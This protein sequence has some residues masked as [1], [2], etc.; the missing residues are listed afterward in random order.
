[1][2]DRSSSQLLVASLKRD[3]QSHINEGANYVWE[4]YR[5]EPFVHKFSEAIYTFQERVDELISVENSIDLEL[6]S[7]DTCLYKQQSFQDI[8]GKI[9]KS[10]DD[11]SLRLYS[12]LAQ[13]VQQLDEQIEKKLAIRLQ[14]AIIMWTNAL[15]Q[16]NN[17]ENNFDEQQKRRRS[18]FADEDDVLV[19][20]KTNN[21]QTPTIR[22]LLHQLRTSNQLLYVAPPMNDAREQLILELYEYEGIITNQKRIQHSRYQLGIESESEYKTTF[23]SLLNKLPLT[24]K[25]LEDA[26]ETIGSLITAADDYVNTWLDFQSL[27]DLQTDQ[28]YARLG[29][30]ITNWMSCLNEMKDARKTFDTQ[31]TLK[32]FGPITIDYNK[33]QTKVTMKYDSWHKEIL[34]KFGTMLSQ[35]MHEFHAH[36]SKA[37]TDLESQSLEAS[38]TAEAVGV[39]TYVQALKRKMKNWEKQV[40]EYKD[41]QKILERQRYQF[42][43]NWLYVDN[44]EG[45]WGAFNEILSRKNSS[46]QNQVVQLRN[47]ITAEDKIVETRTNDLL[48]EWEKDKP[49]AGHLSPEDALAQLSTYDIKLMK[50]KDERDNIIKAK[51][52][53]EITESTS[54][55][56]QSAQNRVRVQVALEELLDLKG[57][58]NELMLIWKQINELKEKQW[59]TIQPRKLRQSLEELVQQL[60]NLPQRL[61]QYDS[62]QHVKNVLQQ[63][64]KVNIL[65][66]EL[67]SE[68][69]KE[70][71]WKQLMRR[72]SIIWNLNDMTLGQVWSIDLQRHESIIREILTIAQGE[73][74]L[75]EF[76]KQVSEIWKTYQLELINYQQKCKVIK[77]WDDLFNKIKEH[78]NSI[79]A[80]KLS[81]Y[82]K[83]FEEEANVW[84]DR[85]N[86]INALFDVW[87]DVQRRW[88]YLDG[89]FGSSA[90]IKHLLPVETSRFQSVSTEFLSLMKRV[91]KSPLVIDVLNIQG[92]QK[93]LERLAE[94]LAKIQKALGEY[95]ERERASFP[96]FYFVGDEDL[97][98][99]IGNSK[100]IGR[101]QKHFKK[102]FAGVHTLLMNEDN[103]IVNGVVSKEGEEV[104]F[105]NHISIMDS[106][107]NEWLTKV[108]KEISLTL[109]KLLS[110][111]IPE[112]IKIQENLADTNAFIQWLDQYQAQLVVLAFQ[113]SWSESIERIL[114]QKSKTNNNDILPNALQGI[115]S[116]LGILANM[117]LGDQPTVRRR[118][119]EHLIIEHVHKRDCTRALIEKKIGDAR[120]F[121]WLSQMRLYFDPTI[122]NVLEQLK[123]RMANA[124]FHYGF[125]YLGIQDRLVQTPLTDR[126]FLTMTQALNAKFGGSPFGPAGT[127]KTESV[128]AL[129]HALGRFVLV[130]NCD[131]SFDFQ[132]MG[133]LFTGLC[134]V[135]AWGCFDEFNRLEERMLSAVSQQIQTIQE[136]LREL[137]H[138]DNKSVLKIELVG[139]SV[140]VN[141]NMAIFIT[142]NPGYAG[143]SNLPDNLKMLFRSLAMTVPDKVLI[144]QV[145]LYSQGFRQ[146]ELLA[147]KIVPLFTLCSE[148]LSQ[149]SHY[150]FGLRA[151]KNVLVMAG[152]LKRDR[153]KSDEQKNESEQEI[154]IQA[155]MDSFVPRL[156]ADDLVLLNS[157]LNDVFPRAAYVRP[158]MTKLKE[159]IQK[160][161]KEMFLICDELWMEKVLQL[162]QIINLNHGLMLVGPSGCGKTT[163]WRVLLTVLNRLENSDGQ[164]H[165]I[166]PKAISKDDLYG[167]LD[168]NTREWTDGLFTHILRKIIDNV[169]GELS[170]RQW[171][172]FDGDVDPEWVE[173]LNSVL[174]DN[175]LLTLP[176]GERLNLPPNVRV[177]FEVQDLRYATL[178]TVSR[179]GMI[180]FSEDVLSLSM[181]FENYFLRVQNVPVSDEEVETSFPSSLTGGDIKTTNDDNQTLSTTV[182]IQ[183]LIVNILKPHFQHDNSLVIK[184]LDFA[185]SQEHIM[186]F[187]RLRPLNSLFSMLNQGIRNILKYNQ[188]HP[189]FPMAQQQ[190][191]LYMT[192]WLIYSL[193]WSFVGDCKSKIRHEFGEYIRAVTTI[194]MPANQSIPLIDYEVTMDGEFS[195]WISKV[196]SIEIE[197]HR[198][199]ATD[200]VIPTIDTIRHETLLNT[201]LAEHK[202]LVLCGPPGSGKTMTLFSAL[203][204]LPDFEVVGLNFSSATTPELMLKT[205]DHYCEYRKTPNGLVLSPIQLNSWIIVFCDEIN[206]PDEDKYGTQRVISFIRQILE[207][208]GFYRTSDQQWVKLERLQF[209]GACNPPTDPGRKPLSHRFLRHVPIIYVDY[210][211]ETSL[212]QIYGTFNRAMLRIIPP[213]KPWADSLTNAMVEFYLLSQER[214]TVDMQPHYIYSPREMTRWVRG[215]FEAIRPLENLPVEGLVRL[216]AHE[217]LRLFQDRLV[218]DDERIWTEEQI[219]FIARKHFPNID[220]LTALQ[221]PILYSNWLSKDYLP[222]E[223]EKLREYVRARLKIFYEEELDV[224]L[225]LFNEV[226]DHVLRIDRVFRQPQGH[227]LLIGVSGSGKTT[228]SRFVAWINGLHVFQI[229]VH[230]KY[231][232]QDFDEDLRTVLRRSGCK[233]EKIAFILDESNMLDSSFLERMNT[234]LANGEVPGLFEGDEYTTLMTQCKEGAQRDGLMLN[235]PEELYKWFT[236]EV[237]KN[238]HVVFTMNPSSEG[239]KDRAA[240]SPALFNRCVL[241]W[242]G[243]WSLQALHQVGKEFTNSI[244]L[245]SASSSNSTPNDRESVIQ[246][247]VYVHQ[248]LQQA[249]L[250]LQ[251]KG[252][253]TVFITPR[254]YIDF[255]NHFV[256]LYHEKRA[257]LE[258]EQLHL[259]K[260]LDKIKETMKDVEE[261]QKS[262]AIKRNELEQKNTA[263][264]LKLKE[265]I[266]DQQEAEKQKI[267]SQELQTRL[268]EQLKE[269]AINKKQVTSQLENVEPAVIEAQQAV[270]GIKRQHLVEIRTLPNPPPLVKLAL[271]AICLLLDQETTD[272]KTIRGVIMKDD[273]I[274]TIIQFKT[275][276]VQEDVRDKMRVRYV[277][278]PDFTYEKVNRASQACGPMVK[279]ARAQLDYADMLHQVEPLRNKLQQLEDDANV[280]RV[281]ADGLIKLIENLEKSITQ[282]KVEYADLIAQAQ[283]I[284]TDLVNVESKVQRSVALLKSL[285]AEQQRW[286]LTSQSFLTQ[287]STMVGD[288]LLCSAFMA[289]AGYY[290]QITRQQLFK[291]WTHHI[292]Q[293]KINFHHQL[294]RV[295]YL[296]NADERL[297]WQA[298]SLPVDDLCTENAIMLKRFNRF[299]LI[300]DPS[301]Q[302]AEF[303][304]NAYQD[305]KI[306]KTSFLD[307]SFRKNL[308]SALRFGNPLVVQDVERYDPILN[309]VLNREVRRTGGRTLITIGDQDIDLSPAFSIFLFTRDPS[310]DFPPDICSRVTFVNF[311]VTRASLQ[312]QCLSQVLKVERPDVDEKRRDLLKL[313]GE[314]QQRL[315]HLEKDLLES[316]NN[317]KGRILD[318][319]TIISRLETLKREAFDITKK[320]QETDQIM[321]EIENV[322][323]QYYTLSVACSSI[324]FTMESLNQVHFL[325]QYSLQFFFEMFNAIFTNNNHLIN[326]TDPL[327]RLQIITNDLFQMIY[328]RIALGML[329]EDRIVLAL[330]LVRIY[331]KSL[332]TEPNYDEEYDIL[333]RGSSATTTTHK[334]DQITIEGLTQQQTDAMIKLSKLPAFKNLQSQV[335]SNPDF[336]KWIEE[337]N[338]ELNVPHLWSELTPLTP[339]GKIFYQLLMIQVFRPDRFLSAARIFVSHVFG[340][341]FLSAADQVLDLGPIVENEIVSNK[342]ILMC[343]VPGY[344]ASS[345]VEDLA[346]QTNQQLISI[347]IGSAEG[348]NQAENSIASSARQGRWVLL[349]NVHLAPQW[350]ITLE[351][352][353]HAMPAHN[354]FRLFLSMEIHPKLPSNLLRMG[355]I[356]V[357]EPAPGI[358]ANLLRTFS[359]IPSLRMNKIPNERSRLYFLLAWFHAVIQERLRYVPLGWSKHYEFTEADLKCALDTIDIW[360]DLIAM[361]R[362]NLPIDKIPWEALR[363]LLSQCIYGGRIDN[364]FDQRL[365]NGFLSK[366]FS[367]TSLNTDMKLIIEEQDEKLQQ[368]LV[369]TMP[370]GVKRE[371]FVTWIEQT[372]RTLIQQPSWLGLPNNA[373][374]VLLTTRARE[375]LAK[376]LKMSSIITND[377]EDI[378]ENILND[379]TTIDTSI[380]GKTRSETGDSRPAWMKQ[381]HNSCVTWLKLLPTKVTTMRRT[382]ENI[383]DPLFRF[384]EREVNTGSKLLSVVQSDLRDIIAVCETKKKQTNY[385]RQLISDLIKGKTKI[386]INP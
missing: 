99:I 326:K 355:R 164:A 288:V 152:N 31:E 294:A 224:Q 334:Q 266:K 329:H 356:F 375:T 303:I 46:I 330:L 153:I 199:A 122:T 177:M 45:E 160:V 175:K 348:F 246:S 36:V 307:D 239:L 291:T 240:T 253:R 7:L 345:R 350:L 69:L 171:I 59:I 182:A 115:E 13:W 358:K 86:R 142:M 209:V 185:L 85:L 311:T 87:I 202:P 231:T 37:R 349:K 251:K 378:T 107:I 373:E 235:S 83:E 161:S 282:Y 119:L 386:N 252:S 35:D 207:H 337:I 70:R 290:D 313:Q 49:V 384:F 299:P 271:E 63:Y 367:L 361:G 223:Q 151:L 365:L 10:V 254:H 196:P 6:K 8:L 320:V 24:S 259:N 178:A 131:E 374:I 90:D 229:K 12:N 293:K 354:Q 245:E 118:K 191:E 357:Y 308:E 227:V 102:M 371:Q 26:Y 228:L 78:I 292:D 39:I 91:S 383:K 281:K 214:F 29:K 97:L 173:N 139:K 273:F 310:V 197:T 30:D 3:I 176:N 155:I 222:I 109:A 72:M 113:V 204:A 247:F 183:R 181:I 242:M 25:P 84:E 237:I 143:R 22:T 162:Y 67:K 53:L 159:E 296:S 277:S 187:T 55:T 289:Y 381:L 112:L 19:S 51:E 257:G 213:L 380:Q 100:N 201:W 89:I 147:S 15:K 62:Y 219:D 352:R 167:F 233:G 129:G 234:L 208:G 370:D 205:F 34:S 377:E 250:K 366:L 275:E 312:S 279:W 124:E 268:Q 269:I 372:L 145:M 298:N 128:K 256:K 241:N 103:T 286:E 336:P 328:T 258:E 206:L 353:L 180:W 344:D 195:P 264:N 125:E 301:G 57:V 220:H 93:T 261:L 169:R 14:T 278:N 339:I 369:V 232:S 52:A 132:A 255:I 104:H 80:M 243:D 382:A 101:L 322:S 179:C 324:Y 68:A 157:L 236:N 38:T 75:E 165:V 218:G 267:T 9:Q 186:D 309:P 137:A 74:A 325:Y 287:I 141:P 135:G 230:N 144:A 2:A 321:K 158:E 66:T 323:K 225:V 71:H 154:V 300:I 210:P 297:K 5:L 215:I 342:P 193:L 27:W 335:L 73:K 146:A 138:S 18:T 376:L 184:A 120:N 316:L 327:E 351:K 50:L 76:L 77:G 156:I 314:F 217:A 117:V 32:H 200:L 359:T 364:P 262:L 1:L 82:F 226:L 170:K 238:L 332:N 331:L 121:E 136:A 368:P 338:P 81:P 60:T 362:T 379:Q 333:I 166:D 123:I 212:K 343:S 174:D 64:I 40:D 188:T 126:C 347:A 315:R 133:R 65:V 42:P 306:T 280:N 114:E 47:K 33:V 41:A 211:G 130:F 318:D 150:D 20:S 148:Q 23:K 284:K 106:S 163:A 276:N 340:E 319:D 110:R 270:K 244:D 221:R 127:G 96:R 363:T 283:A 58:W 274:N 98:E 61:R 272:W 198:V 21:D 263:A 92:V 105:Y 248:T 48:C 149:Q 16:G 346:T 116:T 172:I 168:Q 111:A 43:S 341:G 88:V 203:R 79:T 17:N 360:I 285:F 192:R 54:T 108:E 216:W 305:K 295:E 189:D 94:L 4:S 28:L 194:Q 302:A 95:L 265:M 134:Q 317:V 304:V 249:N 385:H 56:N 11:L 140:S 44:V 260:G 190:I